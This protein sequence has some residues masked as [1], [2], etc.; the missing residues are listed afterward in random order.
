MAMAIPV[1]ATS[2]AAEGIDVKHDENILIGDTPENFSAETIKLI[3]DPELNSKIGSAGRK[4]VESK[5]SW[6]MV[7]E[8]LNDIY[9]S[10]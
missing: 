3:R 6:K 9:T 8:R 1:V 10:L 5:Y 2:I 4:L 7:A